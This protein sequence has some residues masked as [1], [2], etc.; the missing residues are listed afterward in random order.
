MPYNS[1]QHLMQ[2]N[3]VASDL[4][5]SE[6]T[7]SNI[8]EIAQAVCEDVEYASLIVGGEIDMRDC[9]SP[10]FRIWMRFMQDNIVELIVTLGVGSVYTKPVNLVFAVIDLAGNGYPKTY[11]I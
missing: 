5:D 9:W 6:N 1:Q 7:L 2:I 8:V 10:D 4:I 3:H 11:T